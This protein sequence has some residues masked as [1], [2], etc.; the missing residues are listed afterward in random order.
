MLSSF[1]K[2]LL[3]LTSLA[4][5]LLVYG[6]TQLSSDLTIALACALAAGLLLLVCR[7]VLGYIK[8]NVPEEVLVVEEVEIKDSDVLAFLVAYALPLVGG[9]APPSQGLWGL[10][11]FLLLAAIVVAKSN[12]LHVNP[13]LGMLGYHFFCI[14]TSAGHTYLFLTKED[15]ILPGRVYG[16]KVT[17]TLFLDKE[18]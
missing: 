6:A 11:M 13:L 4:P 17:N 1:A 8:S 7:F 12:L 15:T 14:K 2:T 10:G 3:V 9:D 18:P 16:A 5:I